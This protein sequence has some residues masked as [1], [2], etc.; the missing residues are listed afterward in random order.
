MTRFSVLGRWGGVPPPAKNLLISPNLEK[1]PL[2]QNFY[3]TPPSIRQSL[4]PSPL[5]TKKKI[6]I[7]N[8]IV[9]CIFRCRYYSCSIFALVSYSLDTQIML[10]FILIDVRYLQKALFSFEKCS[11]RQNHSSSGSLHP[12]KK[13]SLVNFLTP[14]HPLPLFAKPC[15]TFTLQLDDESLS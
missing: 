6:L 7:Y 1:F 14:P 3:S 4:A 2:P 9:N 11:K 8:L 15:S 13:F 10:I 12:V 5:S